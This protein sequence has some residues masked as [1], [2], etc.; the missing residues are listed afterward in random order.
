MEALEEQA[1]VAAGERTS[2]S[3]GLI[4]PS[5]KRRILGMDY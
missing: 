3:P 4:G 1:G 5:Q 2:I